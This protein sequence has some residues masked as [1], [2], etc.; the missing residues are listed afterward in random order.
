MRQYFSCLRKRNLSAALD[1]PA[2]SYWHRLTPTYCPA[3]TILRVK[4]ILITGGGGYMGS[5]LTR[6]LLKLGYEVV[7]ID[8]FMFTDVGIKELRASS[9]SQRG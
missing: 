3:K 5:V 6:K 8:T 9:A 7:V 4:R 2:A 1:F